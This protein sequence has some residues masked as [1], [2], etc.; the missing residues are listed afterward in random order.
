MSLF[1]LTGKVAIIT[2]ASS[3]L[4]ADAAR[5][6]VEHGA[7][8]ALFARRKDKLEAIAEELSSSGKKILTVKCDVSDEEQVKAAVEETIKTFSKIDILINNAGVAIGG[9]VEQ[10]TMD[11][12]QKG[13]DINVGGVYLM[14]KYVIPHMRAQN[15]GKIV[16]VASVNAVL[17]D[18]SPNLARHVYNASKAAV[19]GLTM[20]MAA[21]YMENNI[22]VNSV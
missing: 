1:D 5:S 4:G 13:M 21:S 9:S 6:F 14:S 15:Y 19:R 17:A 20:G 11:Q 3:G 8:V 12:W 16:N 10:L 7:D 2:G 18:K 22:T